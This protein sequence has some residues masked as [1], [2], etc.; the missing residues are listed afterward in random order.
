M[1]LKVRAVIFSQGRLLV[2]KRRKLDHEYYVLPG[3]A[4]E[5]GETAE[6]AL[7]R[8][9]SEETQVKVDKPRLIIVDHAGIDYG[10]QQIYLCNYVGGE[11]AL[12]PDSIEM[13]LNRGGQNNYQP[14]WV[15]MSDLPKLPLLSDKLKA[16]LLQFY[17]D[18]WPEKTVEITS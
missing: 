8:E 1:N 18:K 9:L 7:L 4:I 6:Q 13:E 5:P 14:V 10:D 2:M 15:A 12:R 3:G 11:P 16:T 17:P